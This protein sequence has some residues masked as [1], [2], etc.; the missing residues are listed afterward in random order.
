MCIHVY[1]S[2]SS[3]N[4]KQ[5]TNKSYTSIFAFSKILEKIFSTSGA[6]SESKTEEITTGM[7]TQCNSTGR[8]LCFAQFYHFYLGF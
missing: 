1:T 5:N 6:L 3:G 8:A 2:S 4:S 7:V